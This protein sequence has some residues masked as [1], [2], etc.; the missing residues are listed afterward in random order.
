MLTVG[1][2]LTRVHIAFQKTKI[3]TISIG[4]CTLFA[5]V[6]VTI[7]FKLMQQPT[8]KE[9]SQSSTYHLL[10]T[11]LNNDHYIDFVVHFDILRK[12]EDITIFFI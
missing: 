6:I 7:L 1:D 4:F 2:V 8:L 9:Y 3:I 5:T 10:F 11:S 12:H